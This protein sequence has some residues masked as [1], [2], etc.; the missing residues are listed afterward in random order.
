MKIL[1]IVIPVLAIFFAT[2][3]SFRQFSKGAGAK[4]AVRVNLITFALTALLVACMSFSAFAAPN[5]EQQSAPSPASAVQTDVTGDAAN[6]ATD[7]SKAM[8]YLAAALAV[9]LAG[10]GG[11]IAVGS[12]APAAIGATSEDPKA[13]GKSI[14][15]VALGEGIAIYGLIVSILIYLKL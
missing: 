12:A 5:N 1:L 9:G 13:F 4:K 11:G 2:F 10:I 14:I 7:S 3:L 6:S 8:G 15:F